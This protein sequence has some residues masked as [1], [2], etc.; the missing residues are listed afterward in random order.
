[1]IEESSFDSIVDFF[2]Y[3]APWNRGQALDGFVF[4]GHSKESYKL[5]PNALRPENVEQLWKYVNGGNVNTDQTEFLSLQIDAE[6]QLLREFYKL[7]D[8]QGLGV[9]VANTF[10][11]NLAQTFDAFGARHIDQQSIWLPEDL[12]E[13]T[14]LA[15]HYGI[16]TRLLDWTYDP[17]VALYFAFKGAVETSGKLVV[18]ALNKDHISFL[19]PTVDRINIEFITPHYASNPNLNAQKGLFTLCPV[20]RLSMMEEAKLMQDSKVQLVDR[21][22][23]D[24]FISSTAKED[25]N[26]ALMKKFIV[27]ANNAQEGLRILEKMGYGTSRIFPGYDGVA[28]QVLERNFEDNKSMQPTTDSSAD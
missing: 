6:F 2:E 21:R 17:Y 26:I 11:K 14:A 25:E 23:L 15:Q 8:M 4:R 9:P 28:R 20:K 7:A 10:R 1:M 24:E 18:W 27:T 12:H 19:Q 3:L 16:P 13:A 22:P 5:I